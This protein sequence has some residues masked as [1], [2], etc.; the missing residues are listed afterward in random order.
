MF[1]GLIEDVGTVV[2]VTPRGPGLRLRVATALPLDEVALGD[3]VAVD[4]ACLTV[5]ALGGGSFEA[6]VSHETA[7]TTGLS[8]A[9]PGGRVNLERALRL[10]D[11]LGGHLVTGHV[12]GRARL[13]GVARAGEARDLR[14]EVPSNLS[15]TIVAKGSVAVDGISL[16]VNRCENGWFVV[17][18]IP[19]TAARTTLL[20]KKVG[21]GFNI[22]TDLLG[23]YVVHA[24]AARSA[25]GEKGGGARLA[26]LL[27]EQGYL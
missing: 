12:D 21:S 1:T 8:E 2:A 9:R 11:R 16:T 10:G 7:A 18:V 15:E 5:T 27:E 25:G 3:S 24:I 20:D 22:E 14:F 23:K 19:H 13:A 17:T 6:D 4:G 26:N